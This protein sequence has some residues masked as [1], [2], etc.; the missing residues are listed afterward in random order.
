M[1]H[2]ASTKKIR[3]HGSA[4]L[5]SIELRSPIDFFRNDF[6][7][8]KTEIMDMLQSDEKS[9]FPMSFFLFNSFWYPKI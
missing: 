1:A 7:F 4:L 5:V 2:G 9:D 6:D 3:L 8:C